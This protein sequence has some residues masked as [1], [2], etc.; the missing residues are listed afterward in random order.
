MHS[1]IIR[2]AIAFDQQHHHHHKHV[3]KNDV[4]VVNNLKVC[5]REAGE[6]RQTELVFE[7]LVAVGKLCMMKKMF[8][9]EILTNGEGEKKLKR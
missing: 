5:L 6:M 3:D 8:M 9:Q 4:N 2:Q 1:N 7:Q